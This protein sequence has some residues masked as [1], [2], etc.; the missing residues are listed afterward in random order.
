MEPARH[1]FK[2]RGS[3]I[4]AASGVSHLGAPTITD[5]S[6]L[7]FSLEDTN[8]EEPKVESPPPA[9]PSAPRNKATAP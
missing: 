4:T 6:S 2:S 7:S 5:E 3:T 8:E 9:P 1:A